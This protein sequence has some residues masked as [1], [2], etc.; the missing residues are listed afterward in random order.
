[1]NGEELV[2]RLYTEM[3]EF[4]FLTQY[5]FATNIE[6]ININSWKD[7]KITYSDGRV[8]PSLK[9]LTVPNTPL[10]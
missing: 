6:E 10:T 1:M 2:E 4:S 3:A 9:N 5:L 7:V 8:L